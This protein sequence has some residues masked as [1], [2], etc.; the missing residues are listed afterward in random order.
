MIFLSIS[1]DEISSPAVTSN[2][3]DFLKKF[4]LDEF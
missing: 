2:E 3:R 4:S 1:V